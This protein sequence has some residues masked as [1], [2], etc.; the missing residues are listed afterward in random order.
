M[1]FATMRF[2]HDSVWS[3]VNAHLE[4]HVPEEEECDQWPACSEGDLEREYPESAW[5]SPAQRGDAL[6]LSSTWRGADAVGAQWHLSA[7]HPFPCTV[8]KGVL[9]FHKEVYFYMS[10]SFVCSQLNTHPGTPAGNIWR[11]T[12]ITCKNYSIR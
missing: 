5:R 8:K 10:Q 9:T 12:A 7:P 11:V 3:I 1:V 2:G 6:G 4:T